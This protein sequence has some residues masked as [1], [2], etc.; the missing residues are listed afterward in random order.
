MHPQRAFDGV[1]FIDVAPSEIYLTAVCKK[2]IL[3]RKLH[4]RENGVYKCDFTIK[5]IKENKIL[6]FEAKQ[7]LRLHL[8]L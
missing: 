8:F 1:L 5:H 4:R 2:D 6:R 7:N 3:W